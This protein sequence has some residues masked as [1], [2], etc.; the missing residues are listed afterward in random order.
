MRKQLIKAVF[1]SYKEVLNLGCILVLTRKQKIQ[2][3]SSIPNQLSS[4][5]WD[6]CKGFKALQ[7][8]SICRYF[9]FQV[10]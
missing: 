1:S 8:I 9:T 5:G 2:S 6:L 7:V 4:K 10:A 3:P